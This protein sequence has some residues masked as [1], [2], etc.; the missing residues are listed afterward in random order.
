[1]PPTVHPSAPENKAS[2]LE[3]NMGSHR[4]F[5][6]VLA[7]AGLIVLLLGS[8]ALN[9]GFDQLSSAFNNGFTQGYIGMVIVLICVPRKRRTKSLRVASTF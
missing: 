4:V 5:G 8:T 7:F 6:M 1:L 3:K 9:W 2:L